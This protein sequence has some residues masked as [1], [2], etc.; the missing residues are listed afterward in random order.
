[1]QRGQR[2][3][4]MSFFSDLTA[5]GPTIPSFQADPRARLYVSEKRGHARTPLQQ[6]G[7]LRPSSY[8][9]APWYKKNPRRSAFFYLWSAGNFS[10]FTVQPQE[11]F[12]LLESSERRGGRGRKGGGGEVQT[13]WVL[14]GV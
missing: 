10:T 8:L 4:P 5:L 1:M 14:E 12:L 7:G 13:P 11:L 6:R 9:L 2:D 3:N